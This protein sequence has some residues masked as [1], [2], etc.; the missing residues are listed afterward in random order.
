MAT[1][2]AVEETLG[3]NKA[4]WYHYDIRNDVLYVRLA[5]AR[6]VACFADEQSN[7]TPLVRRQDTDKTVGVTIVN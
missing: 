2:D 5:S 4:L 3:P 1:A 7:G 6:E